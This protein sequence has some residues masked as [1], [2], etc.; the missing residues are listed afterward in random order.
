M[1]IGTGR[2]HPLTINTNTYACLFYSLKYPLTRIRLILVYSGSP[3]GP[4]PINYNP[5]LGHYGSSRGFSGPVYP[6]T[7]PYATQQVYNPSV[8][9][10]PQHYQSQHLIGTY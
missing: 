1:T 5:G 10:Q 4:A 2:L 7:Q 8:G 3:G 6:G 9:Y